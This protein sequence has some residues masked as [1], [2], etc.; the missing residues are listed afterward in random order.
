MSVTIVSTLPAKSM[1]TAATDAANSPDLTVAGIDFASLLLM[2]PAGIIPAAATQTP[3][4][5][6]PAADDTATGDTAALLAALG[7]VNA[8]T[9]RDASAPIE[10]TGGSPAS[11]TAAVSSVSTAATQTMA[12]SAVNVKTDANAEAVITDA[13][14]QAQE[15]TT[16]QPAKFAVASPALPNSSPET[17]KSPTAGESASDVQALVGGSK[18]SP[19][20]QAEQVT[21]Q[22]PI[23]DQNWSSEFTQKVVWLASNDK[24]S[25]QLTLNPPQMGPIEISL[26]VEKGSVSATFA[27]ANADVRDSIESALPKL[28]EM[29]ASA[30]IE[31]GQTNVSAESFRQQNDSWSGSRS[32]AQGMTDNGILAADS[33]LSLTSRGFTGQQGNGLVDIF[34]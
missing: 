20:H 6:S 2:S 31:L 7:F 30:G 10:E 14:L 9:V 18:A 12:T 3:E 4:T 25:A 16:D 1:Q 11:L 27:S 32:T 22:T 5:T 29:F 28:R 24:Q 8:N 19:L 17:S 21:V 26:N 13:G 23:R 33:A 15:P 34:A